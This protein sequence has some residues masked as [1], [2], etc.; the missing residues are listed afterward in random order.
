MHSIALPDPNAVEIDRTDKSWQL[1]YRLA[2]GATI[3]LRV[4]HLSNVDGV[5]EFACE[6]NR[7]G[8]SAIVEL[9]RFLWAPVVLEPGWCE[10]GDGA[11]ALAEFPGE[12]QAEFHQLAWLWTKLTALAEWAPACSDRQ[13]ALTSFSSTASSACPTNSA[14]ESPPRPGR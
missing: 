9:N 10:C 4:T 3:R 12:A 7:P 6:I 5:D 1:T 11:Q 14:S 13:A 8:M 2:T